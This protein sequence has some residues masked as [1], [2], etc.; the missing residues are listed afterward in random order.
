MVSKDATS[1]KRLAYIARRVRF[2]Q[3]LVERAIVTML[4]VSGKVNPADALTKHVEPKTAYREYMARIYNVSY[5]TFA[6]PK[7][8]PTT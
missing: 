6:Q 3:E 1:I 7:E 8:S 4:N 2:L 5:D